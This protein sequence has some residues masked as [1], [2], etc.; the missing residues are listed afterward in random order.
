MTY[1]GKAAR[2][3]GAELAG[4]IAAAGL[5]T[6]LAAGLASARDRAPAS[7]PP[8]KQATASA[9]APAPASRAARQR[10]AWRQR[11]ARRPAPREGC[12]RADYP[13][14][15]WRSTACATPPNVPYPPAPA[16]TVG[17]GNDFS[18]LGAGQITQATGAFDQVVGVTSVTGQRWGSG[19]QVANTYSFQL[20]ARPFTTTA[21]G[22]SARCLGWQQFVYSTTTQQVFIQYWLLRFD[23]ACPAGWT[24]YQ[25][26]QSTNCWRNSA[27]GVSVVPTPLAAL[28]TMSLTGTTGMF[29]NDSAQL[30][31][32]GGTLFTM[33]SPG[34]I[35]NLGDA[36]YG[37][38]FVMVGDCCNTQANF[39]PGSSLTVRTAV[40][41]VNNTPNPPTCLSE[42]YTAET[43][44]L[45]FVGMPPIQPGPGPAIVTLQTNVPG[46][47]PSCTISA[48]SWND[49]PRR[50][51]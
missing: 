38:E 42:G 31:T 23:A 33:T 41:N 1:S 40:T 16:L 46:P 14:L 49:A 43:N 13:R 48:G 5:V 15:R 39:N 11:M 37:V 7:A 36:W 50:R 35:L 6:G 19:P 9:P 24:T 29:G 27:T 30:V 51:D 12:F 25:L 28:Q 32:N 10:Q 34:T 45:T 44:N 17:D 8:A 3:R 22:A 2:G 47:P 4:L 18:A 26:G 20:N 21:C